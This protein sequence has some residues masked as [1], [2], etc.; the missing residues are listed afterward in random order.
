MRRPGRSAAV[1][2]LAAVFA[3]FSPV[4]GAA[5]ADYLGKPV[6]S[7]RLTI[8]GRDTTE[9]ALTEI[10]ETRVGPPLSMA[11]VRETISHLFSLGRFEDVR[12][13]AALA[14]AG[15]TLRYDLSPV[16]PVSKI[17]FAGVSGASG[18]DE[19]D[20]RRAVTDRYGASPSLG[21]A[22]ELADVVSAAL[23][24]RGYLH[25]AVTPRVEMAHDPEHASLVFQVEPHTRTRIGTVDLEGAPAVLRGPLL[26][27][28]RLAS[29]APYQRE[30]L[31]ARIQ[32]YLEARRAA[33]YYEAKLVP[34]V[35]LADGDR[36]ANIVLTLDRGA[37]VRVS[38]TGDPLPADRRAELV[39][40]EREGSVDED[41]LED[42]SNRIEDFF[43][44]QG[45]RDVT[46]PHTRKESGGE[47]LISFAVA[48]GPL[49]RVSGVEI[50]GNASLPRSDLEPRLRLQDQQPFSQAR[51]DADVAS[52][53]DEYRRLGFAAVK[54]QASL[55][56][57]IARP[58]V[59]QVPVVVRIEIDEGVRTIVGSVR[60]AGNAVITESELASVV[61]LKTGA[62]F[63]PGQLLVDR[64][65]VLRQ[66]G[67]RGYQSTTV[68][69]QPQ[70]S[71][72]RTRA[73][74]VFTV[75]EGPRALVDHVLIVGNVRTSVRT[76]ERELRLKTGDPL[77]PDAVNEGERRLAA[78]GLFRRV[79][80]TSVTHGEEARRDLLVTI[81]EA[82]ATTIGYGGG[83]E[84]RLRVVPQGD[85]GNAVER[86]EFAPRAFFEISRR[87]LFGKNRSVTLFGSLSVHPND[88]VSNTGYGLTE[89]RVQSTFREPRLFDT[90]ADG[91]VSATLEQQIR[92]SFTF[93]RRGASLEATRHLTRLFSLTGSYQLQRTE[94][95]SV[96]VSAADQPAIAPLLN[97]LFTTAPLL[98]SS[99][100]G[101]L[102]RDTRDDAVSPQSG[103][104]FSV[105]GQLAARAIGSQ[106]GFAKSFLTAQT[107][108]QIR[109]TRGVVFAG[110]A[111]LG[112]ATEFASDTPIPEPE[113]FFAG[114]D[115]TVRGFALDTLGV[116][117]QTIDA[118][119]F[120]IGGDATAILNGELRVP[121]RGSLSAVG[122]LDTGN[123]FQHVADLD[124]GQFRTAVGFGV[125]YR[126]PIGPIRVDLGF[127]VHPQP[128]ESLTA[129]FITFG[130]A[131]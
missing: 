29:G 8:E 115:T 129:W 94:L 11:E 38:F 74:L 91:F 68:D 66:Y 85:T 113:R 28:L 9:A 52:I 110:S 111:R 53:L 103:Q 45:Y 32:K 120:P 125:R 62:P 23:R 84:G 102:I 42:S 69:A 107:F 18:I 15:V 67:S 72:D 33:G 118:N 4:A 24:E 98:L 41:L 70:F 114:G 51:L 87:N 108:R 14:G 105:N 75:R 39:P 26:D 99:L 37:R 73:D 122:F 76:I 127:K 65:Q 112:L 44:A 130:Q 25:A 119:G 36:V 117:G 31:A 12:V 47:L 63:V 123:V 59:A 6:V 78:L 82:P 131:F 104:Y 22:A 57:E 128:G 58:G 48:K 34:T 30:V 50:T 83:G 49:Y 81:E 43:R 124:P 96:N 116:R 92:T 7:V 21:R 109:R 60:F 89:Y 86:L 17:E 35:H 93:A 2:A 19:G 56:L 106:V 54:A 79:R 71:T 97:R 100:G 1:L 5:V 80:I 3:A 88:S 64:D 55:E 101:S 13:D 126:S 16:H 40:V 90:F 46:A 77:S 121:V 61:G 95:V 20:L 10:V 27:E